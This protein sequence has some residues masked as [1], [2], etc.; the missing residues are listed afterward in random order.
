MVNLAVRRARIVCPVTN[1]RNFLLLH[2]VVEVAVEPL[3][4]KKRFMHEGYTD[5]YGLKVSFQAA[6]FRLRLSKRKIRV[7]VLL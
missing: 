4:E 5:K 3:K 6:M 1:S 2:K 7:M